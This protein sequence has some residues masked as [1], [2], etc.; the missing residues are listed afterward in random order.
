MPVPWRENPTLAL[1]AVLLS[2]TLLVAPT[3]VNP[4]AEQYLAVLFTMLLYVAPP[5]IVMQSVPE[6][7]TWLEVTLLRSELSMRISFMLKLLRL[8]PIAW[9]LS[10]PAPAKTMPNSEPLK[11]WL[12]DTLLN[13]LPPRKSKHSLVMLET[14]SQLNRLL[15]PLFTAAKSL[16]RLKP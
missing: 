1:T 14:K 16:L 11:H 2:R 8:L 4:L 9:L 3:T 10:V 12:K 13:T 5:N 7:L 6:E 15:P